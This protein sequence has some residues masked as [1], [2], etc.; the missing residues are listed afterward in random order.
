MII[1]DIDRDDFC[2]ILCLFL[3]LIIFIFDFQ[4]VYPTHV[5]LTIG[6]VIFCFALHPLDVYSP[7]RRNRRKLD[8][9]GA[10]VS[11]E[12]VAIKEDEFE[13]PNEDKKGEGDANIKKNILWNEERSGVLDNLNEVD[14]DVERKGR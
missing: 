6:H 2:C 8:L 9:N 3:M 13:A 12:N 7:D 10:G 14:D 5:C 4:G 11:C 1:S